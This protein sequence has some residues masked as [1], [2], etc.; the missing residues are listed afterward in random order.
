MLLD[1]PL[2]AP[3]TKSRAEVSFGAIERIEDALTL[4][5]RYQIHCQQM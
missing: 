5:R 1:D 4:A 3:K 2:R